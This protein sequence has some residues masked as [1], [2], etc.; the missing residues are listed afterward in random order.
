M[1]SAL[2]LV[3]RHSAAAARVVHWYRRRQARRFEPSWEAIL[4]A[5]GDRWPDALRAAEDGPRVLLATSTGGHP[6][7]PSM[8]SLLAVALTMRGASA[9]FLLCD[10]ILPACQMVEIGLQS[11]RSFVAGGPQRYQCASCFPRGLRLYQPLGLPIHRYG[12]LVTAEERQSAAALSA[13]TP[14]AELAALTVDCVPIGEH[15]RAGA[16]RYYARSTLDDEPLGVPRVATL[17]GRARCSRCTSR[18]A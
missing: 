3:T 6:S 1:K 8:D 16:L 17:R 12:S 4:A 11:P 9:H 15:A 13:D 2:K 5:S 7:S 18:V 10:E 14:A